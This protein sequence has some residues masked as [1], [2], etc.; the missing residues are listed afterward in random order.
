MSQ[1]PSSVCSTEEGIHLICHNSM[2][3]AKPEEVFGI[4]RASLLQVGVT[5]DD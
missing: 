3:A 2:A 5:Y 4:W 1:T